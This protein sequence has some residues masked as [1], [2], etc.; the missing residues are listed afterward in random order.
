MEYWIKVEVLVEADTEKK[1]KETML[2]LPDYIDQI[3]EVFV[4]RIIKAED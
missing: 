2:S 3:T 1:A 4:D